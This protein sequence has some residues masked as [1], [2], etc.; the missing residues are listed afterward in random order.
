MAKTRSPN[1]LADEL[2]R[3]RVQIAALEEQEATLKRQIIA[4]GV[5]KAVGRLFAV[6]VV[7]AAVTSIDYKGLLEKLKP[8]QRLL[9]QFTTINERTQVRVTPLASAVV[10]NN[11]EE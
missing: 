6:T 2:G 3:L 10:S 7:K 4:A 9:K 8:S 11:P 1:V 5:D